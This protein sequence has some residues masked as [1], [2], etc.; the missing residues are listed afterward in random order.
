MLD[1]GGNFFAKW[2]IVVW[3]VMD[4][5]LADRSGPVR[6]L[7][8]IAL[9]HT[10]SHDIHL[11]NGY[12]WSLPY[13]QSSLMSLIDFL[14][15]PTV[16]LTLPA[17]PTLT[18]D[19]LIKLDT[20]WTV[21]PARNLEAECVI[22]G[23]WWEVLSHVASSRICMKMLFCTLRNLSGVVSRGNLFH[24]FSSVFLRLPFY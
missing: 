9:P 18:G 17:C 2:V 13:I 16:I 11:V 15:F 8:L 6:L 3:I 1:G 7:I 4:P 20:L 21:A 19:R 22:Y 5:F 12:L 23:D 10:Y 14:T 24:I